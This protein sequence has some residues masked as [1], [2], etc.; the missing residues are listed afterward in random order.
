MVSFRV[1]L[2]LA[3]ESTPRRVRKRRQDFELRLIMIRHQA[4]LAGAA[5]GIGQSAVQLPNTISPGG[6]GRAVSVWMVL[7]VFCLFMANVDAAV[8]SQ[9]AGASRLPLPPNELVSKGAVWLY[10][11]EGSDLGVSWRSLDFGDSTWKSGSAPLGYGGS[12][13]NPPAPEATVVNGGSDT[14]RFI[15]TYFRKRFDLRDP[16]ALTGLTLHLQR[17]DGAVIYL[18]GT[19]VFRSNMPADNITFN[20]LASIDEASDSLV[21]H[22]AAI[23]AKL[24]VRGANVLAV[25]VHQGSRTSNS[26]RFD[27]A[28]TAQSATGFVI[29]SPLEGDVFCAGTSHLITWTGGDAAWNVDIALVDVPSWTVS[30]WIA[31]GT[32]NDGSE[33]WNIPAALPSSSYLIYIQE[34][35]QM[36]WTYGGTFFVNPP[37]TLTCAPNKTVECN[38]D[39][40]FDPPKATSC[41]AAEVKITVLSTVTNSA[42]CPTIITRTWQATDCS[43]NTVFCRQTVTVVDKTPPILVCTPDKTVDCK[44]D[45]TFDEPT[46]KDACCGTD[47]TLSS[48]TVT[49]STVPLTITKTWTAI[50]C[51]GNSAQCSQTVMVLGDCCAEVPANLVLWL[52]F[53]EPSGSTSAN[54]F[55]GGNIGTHLNGPAVISGFVSNSLCFDGVSQFVSV[56]D[57]AALNPGANDD[58]SIDAWVKRDPNSGNSPP[59]VIVDKRDPQ[60]IVGYSLAVSFGNLIFQMGSPAGSFTNYRDTGVVPADNQWHFVAVTVNRASTTGG[61]FYIDGVP[62]GTFDPTLHSGSLSNGS[63]FLVGTTP[64]G[65]A[66]PWMGCIDEVEFFRR[67]IT[68]QEVRAIYNAGAAG[69]CKTPCAAPPYLVCAPDKTVTCDT[70]WSFDLPRPSDTN[71]GTNFTITIVGTV[72]NGVCPQVITRTWEAVDCC[73]NKT[74]CSQTVTVVD[75][76]PPELLCAPSKKVECGQEWRFDPPTFKDACCGTNVTLTFTTVTNSVSPLVITRTWVAVD[77][78]KNTSTCSQTVTLPSDCC[79]TISNECVTCAPDGSYTYSF[80]YRNDSGQTVYSVLMAEVGGNAVFPTPLIYLNPPLPTG[81]TRHLTVTINSPDCG[82]LCFFIIPHTETFEDCC[83]LIHCI[84]LPNCCAPRTYTT[85]PDF[86]EG[87]LLNLVNSNGQL[88]FPDRITPFPYVNIA[89]TDRGTMLRIHTGTGAL[90]GEYRTAPGLLG[91]QKQPSRTTVDRFGNVWLANRAESSGGQGSITRI[92]LVIGGTRCDSAGIPQVNGQY[93]KP[94]FIYNSGAIDRDGDGL[95]KTSYG[96]GNVLAWDNAAPVSIDNNGGVTAAEDELII[97]YARTAGTGARTMAIDSN[98]DLWVGGFF[99]KLHQKMNGITA[100]PVPGTL[101]IGAGSSGGYGGLIDGAGYLWSSGRTTGLIRHDTIS[102]AGTNLGPTGGNYGIAIDPCTGNVWHDNL[103]AYGSPNDIGNKI[104]VRSPGGALIGSPSGYAHGSSYAQGCTVD[105]NGN[106]WVAHSILGNP[107][108]V[109]RL[110]TV[111]VFVGNVPLPIYLGRSVNGPTGVAVDAQGK[112]WV[113]NYSSHTAM[114]IDPNNP[115]ASPAGTVDLIVDLNYA[116]QSGNAGPYNYS[117]K[118][119]YSAIGVTNPSGF[120]NVIHD[121]C[122]DGADWGKLSWTVSPGTVVNVEVRAADTI[123]ALP[124]KPWVQVKNGIS[125]CGTKVLGRHLEIRVTLFKKSACIDDKSCLYDLTVECCRPA[126]SAGSAPCDTHGEP[127]V[128]WASPIQICDPAPFTTNLP[129]TILHPGGLA[130]EVNFAVNG[131]NLLSAKIAAGTPPTRSLVDFVHTYPAGS[132]SVE[133]L[134]NDRVN[135]P[136]R[137]V[138]A[139]IVGDVTPPAWGT[140]LS[141]ST[142]AFSA[143][144]PLFQPILT[145]DCAQPA[146]IRITQDP[147]PGALV[148]QGS[149]LITLVATDPFGNP[150]TNV[151]AFTVAP[152]LSINSPRSYDVFPMGTNVPVTVQI[153]GN[154]TDVVRVN[155]YAGSN[156]VGASTRAPFEA[157]LSDLPAGAHALMAEAVNPSGL[158]SRSQPVLIF[159]GTTEPAQIAFSIS[160]NGFVLAWPSGRTLQSADDASGPWTDVPGAVSPFTAELAST[161]KFFRVR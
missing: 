78:C 50:D 159:V 133:L 122:T 48:S 107:N 45:W 87:V 20:T 42:P 104:F 140:N 124:T 111:G 112:I 32:P 14:G 95:L 29:T 18:N 139:V 108:S 69:K 37:L 43:T 160:A 47:V 134:I 153:A 71:C 58:F 52:P 83:S 100:L 90:L 19:E 141:L 73:N 101:F 132:N 105:D 77:C 126:S 150:S 16:A 5:P 113:S 62:T 148:E 74:K 6:W 128:D 91:L 51:C 115:S 65:G 119:G 7:G 85:T 67:A 56:P 53:D 15:T 2:N 54:L 1:Y 17:E 55:V 155:F 102:L 149:T 86:N 131:A 49:N 24:L 36:T 127:L 21:F 61:R 81:Q 63:P 34:V 161:Q 13:R 76:T 135:E 98:N 4:T 92:A 96:A 3:V 143:V 154:V 25:E 97:N 40:R 137:R 117:D 116:G 27:L 23:D 8:T 38:T 144:V 11:D 39:W 129:A 123:L 118:T 147:R 70:A 41:C 152:V 66:A 64:L 110:T 79:A 151:T 68:A 109:G 84:N 142:N 60:T 88:C 82:K 157:T 156:L 30:N 72:T 145:D 33:L 146:D 59:R 93:L 121:A 31:S 120:W 94:P 80:D 114:R 125:F 75:N 106:V 28:L 12:Q 22:S 130:M 26:M 46:F 158:V 9:A 136:V 57:Y 138:I 89:C 99:N 35:G 10:H 103:G 44:S